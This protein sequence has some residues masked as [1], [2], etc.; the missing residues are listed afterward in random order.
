MRARRELRGEEG[1]GPRGSLCRAAAIDFRGSGTSGAINSPIPGGLRFRF[2]NLVINPL[3]PAARA[4]SPCLVLPRSSARVWI[5]ITDDII[6]LPGESQTPTP[7]GWTGKGRREGRGGRA[8]EGEE[9]EG[10]TGPG[11]GS[12][13]GWK[14]RPGGREPTAPVKASVSGPPSSLATSLRS[15]TRSLPPESSHLATGRD[16]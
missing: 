3:R 11:E 14:D 8:V 2:N 13:H 7:I 5:Y 12:H 6:L 1:A 4:P 15:P 9:R 16:A 10:R